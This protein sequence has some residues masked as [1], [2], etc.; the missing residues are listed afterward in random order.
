MAEVNGEKKLVR[1][2]P[3]EAEVTGWIEHAKTLPREIEY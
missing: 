1:R 3:T 2:E